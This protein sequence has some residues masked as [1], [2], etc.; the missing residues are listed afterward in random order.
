V[1][2]DIIGQ[3]LRRQRIKKQFTQQR[4]ATVAGVSSRFLNQLENGSGNISVLRLANVC[5]ALEMPLSKLFEGVGP[6]GVSIVTLV[7]LRGAG[8]S[9]VGAL[10]ARRLGQ[11]FVEL[12]ELVC[13]EAALS[14]QEIFE[15]GGID[16]Y[17]EL[18]DTT[19]RRLLR[20]PAPM[21]LSTGGSFVCSERNWAWMRAQSLTVWL[22]AKPQTHLNRVRA[23]GDFRPMAGRRNALQELQQ[24]LLERQPSYAEAELHLETDLH[25]V[26]EL[27][28]QI[29]AHHS[30]G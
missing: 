13:S 4:L 23:Q 7:G 30:G 16:Y 3:R 21:V 25:S 14:L 2:L 24:L 26:S 1:L 19:V 11:R 5:A 20:A 9:T 28:D 10:L 29:L 6:N 22:Q 15:I 8:K 27:V 18:T 17:H 12:D